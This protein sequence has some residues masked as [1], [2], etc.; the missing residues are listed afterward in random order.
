MLQLFDSWLVGRKSS[1][2]ARGRT[3][4]NSLRRLYRHQ[5]ER[6]LQALTSIQDRMGEL[7][8]LFVAPAREQALVAEPGPGSHCV[9]SRLASCKYAL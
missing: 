6:Y 5:V 4:S 2:R 1:E 7:N 9:G 8:D 3:Q